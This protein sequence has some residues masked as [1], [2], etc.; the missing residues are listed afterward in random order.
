MTKSYSYFPRKRSLSKNCNKF[1][2]R[3]KGHFILFVFNS[4]KITGKA[5][6]STYRKHILFN[7]Q[8]EIFTLYIAQGILL[9]FFGTRFLTAFQPYKNNSPCH[10]SKV[11]WKGCTTIVCTTILLSCWIFVFM[12]AFFK[13]Y[14]I[15]SV[16]SLFIILRALFTYVYFNCVF[17]II[18]QYS[19]KISLEPYTL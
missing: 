12:S 15:Y 9:R 10:T 6:D 16:K 8:N 14:N 19:S 2:I 1:I 5:A 13:L 3:D 18:V 11:L 7:K 17:R 4:I